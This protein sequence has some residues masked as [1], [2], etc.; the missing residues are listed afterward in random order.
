M[1][2][3]LLN[4]NVTTMADGGKSYQKGSK[5][6]E[7]LLPLPILE[8]LVNEGSATL[9]EGPIP[10]GTEGDMLPETDRIEELM[11]YTVAELREMA[12]EYEIDLSGVRKKADIAAVLAEELPAEESGEGS[13]EAED[14]E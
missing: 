1:D 5:V 10:D 14:G 2:T 4:T 13:K 9:I 12:K 3:Y 8:A 7:A 6:N 11:E